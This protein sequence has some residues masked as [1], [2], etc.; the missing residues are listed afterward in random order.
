MNVRF[1]GHGQLTGEASDVVEREVD[2]LDRRLDAMNDELRR[3]DIA[4]ERS[5]RDGSHT[6]RLLLELPARHLITTGT[7]PT[8]ATALRNAFRDLDRA[9][10]TWL[11]RL[12]REP[13][14]RRAAHIRETVET[15]ADTA[16]T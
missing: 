8:R 13:E 15:A 6:A 11:A 16:R 4:V 14:A 2:R 5:H 7:G 9:L 3:L 12:R 10:E 1:H